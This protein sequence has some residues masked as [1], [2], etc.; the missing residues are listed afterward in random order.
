MGQRSPV[1]DQAGE[2]RQIPHAV[3]PEDCPELECVKTLLPAE[4]LAA[5]AYRAA[6]LKTGADRVLIAQGLIGEDTYL[7]RFSM[8]SG[9]RLADF[10]RI[11]RADIDLADADVRFAARSGMLRM[12]IDSRPVLVVCLR[13]DRARLLM[14]IAMTSPRDIGHLRLASE[15]AFA[16][17]LLHR[18]RGIIAHAIEGLRERHPALSAAPDHR[19]PRLR[20]LLRRGCIGVALFGALAIAASYPTAAGSLLALI[21]LAGIGLRLVAS[22]LPVA[23]RIPPRMADADLPV[24]S[25]IVALYREAPSVRQLLGA[26]TALDY[27][28]EKSDIILVIEGD[29]AQTREAIARERPPSCVRVIV[30]PDEGPRTKPKALNVALPFARGQYIAVYDAEDRPD[31][32]Q[33]RLALAA[34]HAGRDDLACV[35]ARLAIENSSDS[36]ITRM[37]AAE[38]A[39]QFDIVMPGYDRLGLPW[40]LGGTSNHFH[41]DKLREACAWDPFNVT[42][43]ADLGLRFARFHYRT[44]T[45]DST[46]WE[47]APIRL[48]PWLRQRTRWMK[49]WMQTW[50][51]HA[52]HPRRY[53]RRTGWRGLIARDLIIGGALLAA[54]AYPAL[55]VVAA[56]MLGEYAVTGEIAHS[57]RFVSKLHGASI[58]GGLGVAM[59]IQLRGLAY[60]GRLKDG[61]V[62]ALTPIYWGLLSWAA[63]RA[64]LQLRSKPFH[65]EKTEHGLATG[66]P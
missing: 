48:M 43:D 20:A 25:V 47:E 55:I 64:L 15:Q 19:R 16:D 24:Y 12:Q 29:D 41:A 66:K 60:R 32:D 53:W 63:W 52:R 61:W 3:W 56:L 33:L 46:T 49:G 1:R 35:Q 42:E 6:N 28:R 31:P 7:H 11:S 36:T 22:L 39:G 8:R 14:R 38:Y 45:I 2:A 10:A 18:T 51:V 21:F 13:D 65:W 4:A 37:F 44:A 17:V 54:L 27:P 50:W 5:A 30:A 26:L 62:L 40:P 34:F 9:I 59:L 57:A 23:R 58:I